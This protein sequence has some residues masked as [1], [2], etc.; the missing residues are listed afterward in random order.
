MGY[1]QLLHFILAVLGYGCI[2]VMK[3]LKFNKMKFNNTAYTTAQL[4][5]SYSKPSDEKQ[6]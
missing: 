2:S 1:G 5:T 3:G 6:Q 4:I